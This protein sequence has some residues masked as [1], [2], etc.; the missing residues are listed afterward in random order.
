[1]AISQAAGA[2]ALVTLARLRADLASGRARRIREA[3]RLSQAEVAEAIGTTQP[4]VAG[5]ESGRRT[6]RGERAARYADLL[7]RL[8]RE[9]S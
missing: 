3:A 8:E 4:A 9:A 6:P 2:D 1:M 5:Y 7:A